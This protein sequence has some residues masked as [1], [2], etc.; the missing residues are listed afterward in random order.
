V[1]TL[2]DRPGVPAS[3]F[4]CDN[5][6][7]NVTFDSAS[8][9]NLESHCAGTNPWYSG[10]AAP[11]SSLSAFNGQNTFGNWQ[12]IVSDNAAQDTGD[13]VEWEL[14]TTP[15]L[16]G[17]CTECGGTTGV[18][19]VTPQSSGRLMLF[20][21]QPNPFETGT[22]IDYALPKESALTLEVFDVGGRLVRSLFDGTKPAGMHR[23]HWDGL[24]S[25]GRPS[26][27]GIYFYRL[28][29]GGESEIKRLNLVR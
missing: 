3:Q 15:P 5:E 28:R 26:A 13:I 14:L 19:Q 6:N 18:V 11:F 22:A 8:G 24:D 17:E 16:S 10:V 20:Q 12:L 23:V 9:F 25:S 4:G 2:L 29:A 21:N 7:M 27:A 1:V